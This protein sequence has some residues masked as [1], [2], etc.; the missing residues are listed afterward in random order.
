M[1]PKIDPPCCQQ[2][3]PD[4][5]YL[6]ATLGVWYPISNFEARCP[7]VQA[8]NIVNCSVIWPMDSNPKDASSEW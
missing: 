1:A 2:R 6:L 3:G 7:T 8:V 4:K 5:E